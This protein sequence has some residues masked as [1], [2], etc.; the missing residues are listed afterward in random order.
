MGADVIRRRLAEVAVP[1]RDGG[2]ASEAIP[3]PGGACGHKGPRPTPIRDATEP[4]RAA[5]LRPAK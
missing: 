3:V 2:D 5:P 4:S 1:A